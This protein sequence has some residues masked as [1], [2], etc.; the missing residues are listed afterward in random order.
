LF[1]PP[2]PGPTRSKE[3]RPRC[4][5]EVVGFVGVVVWLLVLLKMKKADGKD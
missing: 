5:G 1:G 3:K 4:R 2:S